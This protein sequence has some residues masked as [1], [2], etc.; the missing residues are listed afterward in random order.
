MTGDF[1]IL[2]VGFQTD[3][4][5]ALQSLLCVSQSDAADGKNG[6]IRD[7]VADAAPHKVHDIFACG[8]AE[9]GVVAALL[10]IA[11]APIE[12]EGFLIGRGVGDN[13]GPGVMCLFLMRF[14][15]ENNIPLRAKSSIFRQSGPK[16]APGAAR[17][18]RDTE[19]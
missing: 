18:A 14:F 5:H 16:G 15:K 6:G 10:G 1:Y 17:S 19:G 7:G 4:F 12:K 11:G 2:T 13:K 9:S 3:A 8:N